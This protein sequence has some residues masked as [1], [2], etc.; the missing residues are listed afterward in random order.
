MAEKDEAAVTEAGVLN[1][2]EG[3]IVISACWSWSSLEVG[4]GMGSPPGGVGI[5]RLVDTFCD[6][7]ARFE[8]ENDR[9]DCRGE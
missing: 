5:G 3:D 2:G 9:N 8:T 7:F 1:A 6:A 4:P